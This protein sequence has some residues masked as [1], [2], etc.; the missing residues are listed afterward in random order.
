MPFALLFI[1]GVLML[2]SVRGDPQKIGELFARDLTGKQG[3]ATFAA[4]FV[5]VGA[6][7]FWQPAQNVSRLF[8][9]LMVVALIFAAQRRGGNLINRLSSQWAEITTPPARRN[10]G[11]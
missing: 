7:G 4:A 3:F 5:I 2:A 1:G 6:L 10:A 8:L 11:N 9:A